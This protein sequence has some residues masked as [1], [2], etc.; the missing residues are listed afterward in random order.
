M[1]PRYSD[2]FIQNFMDSSKSRPRARCFHLPKIAMPSAICLR[3]L[4]KH[5]RSLDLFQECT[6]NLGPTRD[7]LAPPRHTK[8]SPWLVASHDTSRPANHVAKAND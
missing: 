7:P 6:K 8:S 2:S 5:Y 4:D 3:S 1:D